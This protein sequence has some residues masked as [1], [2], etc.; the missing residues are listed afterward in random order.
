MSSGA[1]APETELARLL[2]TEGHDEGDAGAPKWW[3]GSVPR[4]SQWE[5][6]GELMRRLWLPA[7]LCGVVVVL[8]VWLGVS[9]SSPPKVFRVPLRRLSGLSPEVACLVV[10]GTCGPEEAFD[11]V[12]NNSLQLSF[13]GQIYLGTPPQ[14][15]AVNFDTSSSNLF[16]ASAT[17]D[18][19]PDCDS[20]TKFEAG[21][22]S[23][24]QVLTHGL[25]AILVGAN[26][27]CARPV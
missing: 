5:D 9:Y 18:A 14:A 10:G 2:P 17:C 24:Y 27:R 26:P 4:A 8:V 22:S 3:Y 25:S 16:V 12:L 21:S 6:K 19:H 23:S 15:F 1:G 7:A 20:I 13:Y 11:V